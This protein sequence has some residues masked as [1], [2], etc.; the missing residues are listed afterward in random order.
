MSVQVFT[1]ALETNTVVMTCIA[2]LAQAYDG[3]TK[4]HSIQFS[5]SP[6]F[7]IMC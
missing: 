4:F 7:S 2:P 5:N 6:V 3:A 1:F